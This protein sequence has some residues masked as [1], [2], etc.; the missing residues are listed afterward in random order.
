MKPMDAQSVAEKAVSVIGCGYDLTADLRLSSC[1]TGPSGSR[2]IEMDE[3]LSR[4]LVLPGGIVVP[5]VSPFIKCDKGE[6]TRF[7]TDV[8]S[9]NQMSEQFNQELSLSGKIPSGLF[10]M[11]FDFKGSWQKDA[12]STKGLAFDGWFITLYTIELARTHM[13]LLEDVKREV[14]SSWDP[15][16]LAEFIDKYG[17]HIIVGVKIGGKDVIHIKQLQS[18]SLQPEETQQLLKSLANERFS[19]DFKKRSLS[20]S[21]TIQGKPK[22]GN[23]GAWELHSALTNS[24]MPL[25]SPH[26]QNDDLLSIHI[27]RGGIDLGNHKQWLSTIPEAPNVISMSF[28]PIT[29]LLN[30]VQGCGFLSHAMNLYLRYK[31]P[32]EELA[33]FLEFQLSRQW[34]PAYGDLPLGLYRKRTA[35][36]SLHCVFTGPKLYVNTAQV[37]TENRPVA[38]IRLFLE[39]KRSDHLAIHLQHLSS[40]PK[41]LK[42]SDDHCC[43]PIV[44]A[45]NRGFIK[46]IKRGIF[47]YICTAPIEH[48]TECTEGAAPIVTKAWF[49]VKATGMKKVLFL[50]LGFAMVASAKIR[51]S[52]WD[53]PLTLHQKSGMISNL[54]SGRISRGLTPPQEPRKPDINSGLFAGGPPKPGKAPK[55]SSI[56]DTREMVR[57]PEEHPG[58][59]VITGAKL[60]TEGGKISIKAKYSLL[61]F[62]SEES[63]LM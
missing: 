24:F 4:D 63:T 23:D 26:S 56:V 7:R 31:P 18:S 12:A 60:C 33:E 55:L 44:G 39:G 53:G 42:L 36:S 16:A 9:F 17:T 5:N 37:N 34:A 28:V 21:E 29:S 45:A 50:R 13:K 43:Q 35:S 47:S 19:E 38:G 11:M 30:G 59:W 57:G 14:P 15:A 54:I 62:M 52:E 49:Q 8:L 1:K 51:K 2:L 58:Y 40:L 61:T 46:P 41:I 20:D 22:D 6:R 27:R 25:I 3:P 48:N 32:I 10:N